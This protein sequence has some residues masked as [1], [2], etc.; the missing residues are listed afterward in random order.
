LERVNAELPELVLSADAQSG[1]E[2]RRRIAAQ[3]LDLAFVFDAPSE[4]DLE[5]RECFSVDLIMVASAPDATPEEAASARYIL[6]DWG[7]RFSVMHAKHFL[8]LPTPIMRTSLGRIARDFVLAKGGSAYLAETMVAADIANKR[9]HLVPGAP[10]F[11][12][13]I[14]AVF[15]FGNDRSAVIER[16]LALTDREVSLSAV[17]SGKELE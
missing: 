8:D 14:Y 6:V 1:D 3:T 10:R 15:R 11:S 5:V 13:T 7:T 4:S 16:A 12:R 9:L 17:S 2:L